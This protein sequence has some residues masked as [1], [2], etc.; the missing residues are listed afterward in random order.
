MFEWT[1]YKYTTE[2][3]QQSKTFSQL[4]PST[5]HNPNENGKPYKTNDNF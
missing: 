4:Q 1:T 3:S 5:Q 2:Y